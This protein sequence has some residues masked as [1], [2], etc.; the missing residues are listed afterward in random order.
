MLCINFFAWGLK[1]IINKKIDNFIA[2]FFFTTIYITFGTVVLNI[3]YN[4][5]FWLINNGNGGFVGRSIKENIYY[6]TPLV[7]NQYVIYGLIS[8]TIIFFILSLS[9]K[10]NQ[11]IKISFLPILLIKKIF[12]LFKKK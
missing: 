7:E 6:F 3:F 9:I 8:L 11:F 12:N 4:D 10:L 1:I 5:S 2:K